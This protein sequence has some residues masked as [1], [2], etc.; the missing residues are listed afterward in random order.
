MGSTS[1]IR[2]EPSIDSQA[3]VKSEDGPEITEE[4]VE[5]ISRK[6]GKKF[7]LRSCRL[8]LPALFPQFN[9]LPCY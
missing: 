2:K 6:A 4:D 3:F 8:Y 9:S 7:S 1:T 5:G